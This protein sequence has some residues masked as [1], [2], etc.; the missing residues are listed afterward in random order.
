MQFKK[1]PPPYVS[2]F[3][4]ELNN[5]LKFL[6]NRKPVIDDKSITTAK[7][8]DRAVTNEK[9]ADNAVNGEK[10]ANFS[11][12]SLKLNTDLWEQ[13]NENELPEVTADDI[14]KLLG[15][16]PV[17]DDELSG[18]WGAV[19]KPDTLHNYS[20]DEQVVGTWIT[21]KPLYEK[22][23]EFTGTDASTTGDKEFSVATLLGT[24]PDFVCIY[25]AHWHRSDNEIDNGTYMYT[26]SLCRALIRSNGNLLVTNS[27]SFKQIVIVMR[28]TKSTDTAPDAE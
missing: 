4:P 14:G 19:N 23:I 8:A 17:E 28:Y 25:F 13:I 10:I 27:D 5:M 2:S 12:D 16:V 24:T 26:P 7:L 1:L 18:K 15:V 21:G 11:I 22:T 3:I 6:F 20:T 9:I